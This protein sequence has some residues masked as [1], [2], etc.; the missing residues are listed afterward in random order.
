MSIS[1]QKGALTL[2]TI[3]VMGFIVV[4]SIFFITAIYNIGSSYI[5]AT[6][7]N[8]DA[9]SIY[10]AALR[11]NSRAVLKHTNGCFYVASA[12]SLS[13]LKS[14]GFFNHNYNADE[15]YNTSISFI[16]TNGKIKTLSKIN[17]I[18]NFKDK[19]ELYRVEKYLEVSGINNSSAIYSFPVSSLNVDVKWLNDSGCYVK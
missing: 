13:Q 6:E 14:K 9:E 15:A 11:Y 17:I 4:A 16:T 5:R 12:P 1:R 7:I 10:N 19:K 3:V 8:N 18:F 2:D